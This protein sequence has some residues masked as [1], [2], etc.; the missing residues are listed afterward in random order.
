VRLRKQ[1][2]VHIGKSEDPDAV[3]FLEDMLKK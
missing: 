1:A 3:K 2:L